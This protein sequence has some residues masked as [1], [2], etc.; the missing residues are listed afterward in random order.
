LPGVHRYDIDDLQTIVDANTSQRE[1]AI[2]N[3][4]AIIDKQVHGFLDW[5]RSRQVTPVIE[6]LRRRAN[7]IA[8][9][10]VEKAL[11]RLPYADEHT[12][13]VIQLLAHRLVNKLLHEPTVR[14]RGQAAEGNGFG[15]AHAMRELFGLDNMDGIECDRQQDGC[16]ENSQPACNLQC[17]LP[18]TLS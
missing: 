5:Y 17:I 11:N 4:E 1:A 2:P 3:V 16:Y 12:E 8:R 15:Y 7:E 18:E 10:E 14:L 9:N 6:S 13:Q